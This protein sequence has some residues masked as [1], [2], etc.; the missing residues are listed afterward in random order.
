M[1]GTRVWISD[2]DGIHQTDHPA[3]S[4]HIIRY[5]FELF[6][7]L[8]LF[9]HCMSGQYMQNNCYYHKSSLAGGLATRRRFCCCC[10][11]LWGCMVS[12]HSV[13]SFPRSHSRTSTHALGAYM[14]EHRPDASTPLR[15]V[16]VR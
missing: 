6:I 1:G 10:R 8:Y 2:G 4:V 9:I 15:T 12:S 11:L 16:G 3:G 13:N 14:I 7:Y 5:Y